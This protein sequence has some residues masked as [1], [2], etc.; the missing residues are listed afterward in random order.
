[1]ERFGGRKFVLTLICVAVGAAVELTTARGVTAAFAGLLGTLVAAFGAT[2]SWNTQQWLKSQEGTSE[3]DSG[4][5]VESKI[6][7]VVVPLETDV[8]N[9]KEQVANTQQVVHNL[10][11]A[12]TG[13][14]DQIEKTRKLATIALKA[15]G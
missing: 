3:T 14:A 4:E 7:S 1:M 5:S 8:R 13:M 12:M 6:L 11:E 15:N 2:N 9:T 10:S